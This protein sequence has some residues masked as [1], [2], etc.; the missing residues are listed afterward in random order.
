MKNIVITAT[1]VLGLAVGA[2]VFAYEYVGGYR[3]IAAQDVNGSPVVVIEGEVYQVVSV[4]STVSERENK[5]AWLQ[6][7]IDTLT[8][9]IPF[10]EQAECAN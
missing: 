7:Q 8:A 10:A 9:Q 1:V 4:P 5:R 2:Q 6:A 3:T